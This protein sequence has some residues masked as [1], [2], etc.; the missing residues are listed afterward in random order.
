MAKRLKLKLK[1]QQ[2]LVFAVRGKQ[3]YKGI[4]TPQKQSYSDYH[5]LVP[6]W[7]AEFGSDCSLPEEGVGLGAKCYLRDVFE[8]EAL[9][10]YV[11]ES[12]APVVDF[13]EEIL[14]EVDQTLGIVQP[15]I[16]HES[17]LLA[18]EESSWKKVPRLSWEPGSLEKPLSPE[19]SFGLV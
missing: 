15:C 11:T 17:S 1:P 14:K 3:K 6:V 12:Y 18:V 2:I 9:P 5:D 10:S 7:I 16:V 13:T 19:T 4:I 8:L